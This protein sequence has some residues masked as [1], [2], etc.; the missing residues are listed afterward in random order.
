MPIERLRPNFMFSMVRLILLRELVTEARAVGRH[1]DRVDFVKQAVPVAI[2][3]TTDVSL[4]ELRD[5]SY[6]GRRR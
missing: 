6:G 5:R 4:D 2:Q 1:G 3:C